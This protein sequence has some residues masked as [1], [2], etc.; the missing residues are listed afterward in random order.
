M[1]LNK[2]PVPFFSMFQSYSYHIFPLLP[3]PESIIGFKEKFHMKITISFF[4][5][6]LVDMD[7]KIVF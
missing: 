1:S 5:V 6:H 7:I 3:D 4:L 2:S